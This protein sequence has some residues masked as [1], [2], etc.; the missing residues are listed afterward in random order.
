MDRYNE[1]ID[2]INQAIYEYYILDNAT[3]TDQEY[4]DYYYEMLKFENEHPDLIREDSPSQRVGGEAVDKFEKVRHEK[5]ML[6][7]DD[8]FNEEEI[9]AFDEKIKKKIPHPTYT[10]EPKMDG[11][12][13]S[14]LYKKGILVRAATR[15]DG[16]IGENITANVKTIKS[17][18]LKLTKPIDIEVRGEIYMSKKSF[19]AINEER[20]AKNESLFANPRN[21]AAGSVRQLDSKITAKRNLDFMAYFIPNP[22]DYGL[23]TQTDS[24]NYMKE[25][26]F[27]TNH[28]LNSYAK[29]VDEILKYIKDLNDKR[30][31]LPFAIDGVVLKVDSLKDEEILGFTSRVPRWGIAY[32]FPAEEVLTTLNEIKFTVGRTGKITPNAFFSPVHVDGSIIRKAT[33]HNEDYCIEKDVRI[34]DVISIRKAGDVIPEVVEVKMERRKEN[35]QPFQMI[36]K[37][38]ICEAD[39][40]K[41]DANYFCPNDKCPARKIEGLIHFVSRHAMFIDGFG[42]RIIEE[43]YNMGYLKN[44]VDFYLLYKYKEE[45]MTLEGFGSKSINNLLNGIEASKENSLERLLFA[46]GIRHVGRKTAKIL[47]S[48]YK[49]M[50]ALMNAKFEDLKET[51]D[52]G[53]IIAKSLTSYFA[54]PEN[55]SLINHLKELNVNM[56]FLG[57]TADETNEEINGKTF[58]LTGTLSKPRDYYKEALENLG[59]NVA[60]T[61]T[62]KTDYVV[63]GESPGS[64]YN[65]A[66]ELN[67]EIWNEEQLIKALEK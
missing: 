17:V 16:T 60:G 50:D 42:D 1:L 14:L 3:L 59:G 21:A 56:N 40:V 44:V 62:K 4:D 33:L 34:G 29:N 28:Q 51:P 65:K 19:D 7:F 31:D 27:V 46:L 9:R 13:G 61:V 47:A 36:S 41:K 53:E 64:K 20:K 43:F 11:L 67:I 10:L 6:S 66:Q 58:V 39:L 37:C 15:G 30:K 48:K 63:V 26:G 22:E 35:S 2:I 32:K 55:I 52:I 23:T 12:S 18:P 8:I 5:P 57:S 45:L 38:P 54:D 24:L 49:S 25:L